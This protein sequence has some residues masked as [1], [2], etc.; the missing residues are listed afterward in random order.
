MDYIV[1]L[2]KI[3]RLPTGERFS[4]KSCSDTHGC[5]WKDSAGAR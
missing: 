4:S 1:T 5:V 3:K 2:F